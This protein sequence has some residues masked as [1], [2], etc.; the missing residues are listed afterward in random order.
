MKIKM[1][2]FSQ[3]TSIM[4]FSSTYL[5]YVITYLQKVTF[6]AI[7]KERR[8]FIFVNS[9]EWNGRFFSFSICFYRFGFERFISPPPFALASYFINSC[10]S[11]RTFASVSSYPMMFA[12]WWP[13][14]G[15]WP[16]RRCT[17][18]LRDT[19]RSHQTSD[20]GDETNLQ[21]ITTSN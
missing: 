17:D 2:T 15:L 21:N 12:L 1:F 16:A 4:L 11:Y 5:L 19:W 18:S 3:Q 7:I 9:S 13:A 14:A 20:A 10:K 6:W 8:W